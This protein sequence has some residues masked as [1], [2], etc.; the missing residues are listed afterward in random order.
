MYDYGR[1][2]QSSGCI[3]QI[4]TQSRT[5]IGNTHDV[6]QL[7][8]DHCFDYFQA[9]V[10]SKSNCLPAAIS[11]CNVSLV[12]FAGSR[13]VLEEV[14]IHFLPCEQMMPRHKLPVNR[15][16]TLCLFE[17]SVKGIVGAHQKTSAAGTRGR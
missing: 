17:I 11:L 4:K 5:K 16:Q 12:I 8:V 6:L 14:L 10:D 9:A 13:Y 2:S 3:A 15:Q 7:T 1:R